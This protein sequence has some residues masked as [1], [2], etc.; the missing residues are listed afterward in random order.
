M[1]GAFDGSLKTWSFEGRNLESFYDL[2]EVVH[3]VCYVPSTHTVLISARDYR[4][5]AIDSRSWSFITDY[6]YEQ[7]RF[8]EFKIVKLQRADGADMVFG[9]SECL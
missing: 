9:V 4:L 6:V 2:G 7:S 3:C 1:T 8:N 5:V